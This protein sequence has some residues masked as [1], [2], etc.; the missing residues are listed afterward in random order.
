M[1]KLLGV[2]LLLC[3][4][5]VVS[6]DYVA[7]SDDVTLNDKDINVVHFEAMSYP[8][9][10][11]VAH[12]QGVVVIRVSLDSEGKVEKAMAISGREELIPDCLAN[13]K[14]WKFKPNR[15]KMAILVY[16]FTLP[17]V[18]CGSVTSFF[19]LQGVN[20]AS[21]TGCP[22]VATPTRSHSM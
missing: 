6:T 20:V 5:L 18:D 8:Q 3:L 21:I 19:T 2:V 13:A 22:F 16:S 15:L 10:A 17:P 9:L 14:K 4:A 11:R 7:A 12:V 1:T